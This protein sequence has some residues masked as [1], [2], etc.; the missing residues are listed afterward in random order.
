ME[1]GLFMMPIHRIGRDYDTVLQ[2]DREVIIHA[3]QL[4]FDH[5]WV[6]EHLSAQVEQVTSPLIFLATLIHE[7]KQIKFAQG[8]FNLPHHHPA[9]VA[10]YCAMFDHLAKGRFIMGIGTGGLPCDFELLETL[11]EKDRTGMLK[12]SFD[13]IEALWTT[14]P[15]YSMRG[16]WWNTVIEQNNF[17][18]LGCG[19]VTKPYQKPYPK[20]AISAMS[21]NSSSMRLA[22][23]RG[24]MGISANFIPPVLVKTHW[25]QYVAGCEEAGHKPDPKNWIIAK[26]I[27]VAETDEAAR[28]FTYTD[29]GPLKYYYCYL[30]DLLSKYDLAKMFKNDPDMPDEALTG[31][32]CMDEMVICGSPRTVLEQLVALR[33]AIGPFGQ[34]L[35]VSHDWDMDSGAKWRRSMELMATEVMPAF[36]AATGMDKAAE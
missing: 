6:G 4:G 13:M 10:G 26:S 30:R 32:Y 29:D 24:W 12:E 35:L 25:E 19:V 23:E 9:N 20:V 14:D 3:D 36:R 31:D 22:G 1:L 7:T 2:E 21:P 5:V 18:E 8:V 33:E 34:M 28:E 16:K 17:P 27:F 11:E 15:P